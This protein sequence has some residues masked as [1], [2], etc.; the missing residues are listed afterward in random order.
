MAAFGHGRQVT[1]DDPT[2]IRAVWFSLRSNEQVACNF[3]LPLVAHPEFRRHHRIGWIAVDPVGILAGG[4][5]PQGLMGHR[6]LGDAS[7]VVSEARH[8]DGHVVLIGDLL[9]RGS[10]PRSAQK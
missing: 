2:R 6:L 4:C 5:T 1:S 10:A 8:L 7:G 9:D 3:R